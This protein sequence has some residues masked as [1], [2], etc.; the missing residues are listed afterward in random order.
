MKNVKK[1][2]LL[3]VVLSLASCAAQ[4]PQPDVIVPLKSPVNVVDATL[5]PHMITFPHCLLKGHVI[6][7]TPVVDTPHNLAVTS[8]EMAALESKVMVLGGDSAVIR[9]N[10]LLNNNG[11]YE[12]VLNVD[13]YWCNTPT[14]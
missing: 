7:R 10:R 12:H 3:S 11:Y 4:P 13:A 5:S 2:L 1:Y 8:D 6:V 9:G 14:A